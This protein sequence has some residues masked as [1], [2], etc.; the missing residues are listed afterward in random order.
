MYTTVGYSSPAAS[1]FRPWAT[2]YA[3]KP[4]NAS[5][6]LVK[7]SGRVHLT[8]ALTTLNP[9]SQLVRDQVLDQ[10]TPSLPQFDILNTISRSLDVIKY[11]MYPSPL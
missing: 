5:I 3:R 4:K 2:F 1:A 11:T 8:W 10:I 6:A 7:V 9:D